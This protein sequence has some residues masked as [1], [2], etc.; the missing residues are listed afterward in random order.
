MTLYDKRRN[1]LIN[2]LK[3]KKYRDAYVEESVRVGIPFQIRTIRNG[4]KLKQEELGKLAG[5]KQEA[6]CRLED[7]NYG[8]FTLK[9]LN[10]IAAAFDVGLIVRFAPFS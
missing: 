5:M 10:N 7:P 3:D 1:K 6:I 2:D 4:K 9:T 8:S